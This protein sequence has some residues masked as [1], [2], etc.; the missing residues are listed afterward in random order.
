MSVRLIKGVYSYGP[1]GDKE[2][3]VAPSS[4][5]EWVLYSLRD[6]ISVK[7][8]GERVKRRLCLTR[9]RV[10]SVGVCGRVMDSVYGVRYYV[11]LYEKVNG[12]V[13]EYT[14]RHGGE[15]DVRMHELIPFASMRGSGYELPGS[16]NPE[17][18]IQVVAVTRFG[19]I[20]PMSV[21]LDCEFKVKSVG[22]YEQESVARS[23]PTL[24]K[25]E[26]RVF[27]GSVL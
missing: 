10:G 4:Y 16:L 21:S 27:A 18:Y 14:H 9:C 12:L 8:T 19:L 2:Y 15:K 5:G 13:K 17:F 22:V 11:R 25:G 3:N 20:R 23:A 24:K 1:E 6:T 26:V 7:R